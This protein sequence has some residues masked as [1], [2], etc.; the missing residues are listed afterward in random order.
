MAP[1]TERLDGPPRAKLLSEMGTTMENSN[2]RTRETVPT[3]SSR[4]FSSSGAA[5]RAAW[6]LPLAFPFWLTV[7]YA[8][9]H[10]VTEAER[11]VRCDCSP[12]R[13]WRRTR[14]HRWEWEYGPSDDWRFRSPDYTG[15]MQPIGLATPGYHRLLLDQR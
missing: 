11:H 2:M 15:A 5:R 6:L 9:A 7:W 10:R 3:S 4:S 13:S 14:P 1:E 8:N 12:R